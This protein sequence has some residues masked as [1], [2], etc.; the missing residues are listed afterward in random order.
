M[1]TL[2]ERLLAIESVSA[3]VIARKDGAIVAS[4]I[5]GEEAE[6]LGAMG[7]AAFDSAVRYVGQLS[8]DALRLALFETARGAV[9]VGDLGDTLVIVRSADLSSLGRIRLEVAHAIKNAP[10]VR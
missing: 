5:D 9:Q 4:T 3:A 8:A 1:E 2:L 7:A 10:G 6:A